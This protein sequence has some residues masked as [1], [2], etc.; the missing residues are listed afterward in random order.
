MQAV[1]AYRDARARM[2]ASAPKFCVKTGLSEAWNLKVIEESE[3]S[4][5]DKG[6]NR[7]RELKRAQQQTRQHVRNV[8]GCLGLILGRFRAH[9]G[10]RI[11]R[12]LKTVQQQLREHV[13]KVAGRLGLILGR[14]GAILGRLGAILGRL[15]AILGRLGAILGS[16]WAVLGPSWAVL[17][18]SWAVLGPSWAILGPS[19]ILKWSPKSS[20]THGFP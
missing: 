2:H 19:R 16:S 3:D 17:G 8:A 11:A 4:R 18:P 1:F 12:E 9:K 5:A 6:Q 10:Q 20:K 7:P 15:G 14:L 13:R